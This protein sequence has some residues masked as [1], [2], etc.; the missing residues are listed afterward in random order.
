M[1][2]NCN[3]LISLVLILLKLKYL[4]AVTKLGNCKAELD[5]GQIIDLKTLINKLYI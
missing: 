2:L 4:H 5:D 1:Y 3:K